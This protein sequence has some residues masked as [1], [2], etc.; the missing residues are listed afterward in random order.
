MRARLEDAYR[1]LL[2]IRTR[3]RIAKARVRLQEPTAF[4]RT[5]PDFLVIGAM[6]AG[7]S[8]LYKYLGQHPQSVSSA[9]KEVQYFSRYHDRSLDWYRAHFPTRGYLG[10]RSWRADGPVLTFEASP[11]YLAHPRAPGRVAEVLPGIRS[12]A[13]LRDPADRALSHYE[14]LR[15]LGIERRPLEVALSEEP[16]R[17]GDED[18]QRTGEPYSRRLGRYGYLE[19]GR[20][21]EQLQRWREHFPEDRILVLESSELFASP[22]ATMNRVCRFLEIRAPGSHVEYPNYS[23][24]RGKPAP[25]PPSSGQVDARARIRETLDED[26]RLLTRL[27][28]RR[29][30][31]LAERVDE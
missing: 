12:I 17:L 18:D 30:S 25:R 27:L 5:L 20:Y 26:G 19:L 6:R 16:D 29:P 24:P 11:G 22:R 3:S 7:T 31:W 8:S 21:G 28:G 4:A 23:Y 13:L 10:W 2:S 1:K 14:H 15:R 9:R